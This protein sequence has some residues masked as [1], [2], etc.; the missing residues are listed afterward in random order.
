MRILMK[1]LI[2]LCLVAAPALAQD[3]PIL[4]HRPT[5]R[6]MPTNLSPEC[7]YVESIWGAPCSVDCEVNYVPMW[8]SDNRVLHFKMMT[9][10]NDDPAGSSFDFTNQDGVLLSPNWGNSLKFVEWWAR[11]PSGEFS[12]IPFAGCYCND[13]TGVVSICHDGVLVEE[14]AG[15]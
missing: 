15:K 13:F 3:D 11:E 7:V 5:D 6:R 9:N 12:G 4:I 14:T 1:L 10:D 8:F 2:L